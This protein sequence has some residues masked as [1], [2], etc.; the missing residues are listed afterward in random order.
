[1]RLV[2]L[3]AV[4]VGISV[5]FVATA[6]GHAPGVNTENITPFDCGAL[7]CVLPKAG[8]LNVAKTIND[9]IEENV[10]LR[11]RVLELEGPPGK[12]A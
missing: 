6:A 10:R 9:L 5:V 4:L 3:A 11:A 1:M 12:T 8:F 2:R 7:Y